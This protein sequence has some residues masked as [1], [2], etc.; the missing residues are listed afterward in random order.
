MSSLRNAVKRITHKERSQPRHRQ[1]L[2]IL[3]KKKDYR[4][5]A[6]DYHRK[7]DAIQK[8]R[9]KVSMRNPDE[10]YF[11]MHNA[12]VQDHVHRKTEKARQKEFEAEVG[13]DTIRLMKNQDLAYVRMQKQRD[14]KKIEKLQSS[15]H[16]LEN[17]SAAMSKTVSLKRKHIIF[18]ENRDELE[19]F[20]VATHFNTLPEFTNRA[21]NRPR[22][23]DL[24]NDNVHKRGENLEEETITQLDDELVTTPK[25]IKKQASVLA[26]A[27]ASSYGELMERQKRVS[28]LSRAEA[29]LVMEKLVSQSGTKR[30]IAPA[31]NGFPAQYK[32]R[33]KR[34]R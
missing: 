11:G 10:F 2:G 32:W 22:L 17:D 28:K 7:E 9:E 34:L 30:K 18:V 3:E 27:R 16:F 15:L 21:F 33:Q 4:E 8:L 6:R 31:A 20:D 12:Q 1:H 5:R 25:K 29:H 14:V 13:T 24:R 26:K 19:N 23:A